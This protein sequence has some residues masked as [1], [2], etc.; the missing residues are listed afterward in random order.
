MQASYPEPPHAGVRLRENRDAPAP[1]RD[2][3]APRRVGG[4][5]K[6][7]IEI[8]DDPLDEP[9]GVLVDSLGDRSERRRV[10]AISRLGPRP[11]GLRNLPG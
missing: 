8:V 6:I 1:G 2:T 5:V 10:A 9:I 11:E 3:Q 7:G 4:E